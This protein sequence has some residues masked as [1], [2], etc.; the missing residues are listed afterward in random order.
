MSYNARVLCKWSSVPEQFTVG[1]E[2][3]VI[4]GYILSDSNN[5]FGKSVRFDGITSANNSPIQKIEDMNDRE[6]YGFSEISN[7]K[8]KPVKIKSQPTYFGIGLKNGDMIVY[9]T[10][11]KGVLI[12]NDDDFYVVLDNGLWEYTLD[13]IKYIYR[14]AKSFESIKKGKAQDFLIYPI[15]KKVTMKQ[16]E[17]K[18]GCP[19]E[20]VDK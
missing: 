18:F 20:I 11:D 1:K 9:D 17:E 8:T 4:D 7:R 19:V 2:Y 6:Y 16:V 15:P 10:K 3:N 12:I 5:V 13:N 14:G